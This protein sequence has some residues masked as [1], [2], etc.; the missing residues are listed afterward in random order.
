M[1][2]T[3]FV[4]GATGC[5]GINLIEQ[6]LEQGWEVTAMHRRDSDI[7]LISHL[8]LKRVVGDVTDAQSLKNLIRPGVGCV[9]HVAGNTSLWA[10]SHAEQTKVNIKGTRNMVR[11]AL[12]AG[13]R[14][15]V[16][17][18][19]IVAYGLH[20]GTISEDTPTR[21]NA[22]KINYV[23]SKALAER[24]VRRGLTRGLPAVILNPSNIIGAYD[25]GNWS[26]MFRLVQAGRLPAVPPGGGSFC[27]AREVARMHIVA[28]ER[29]RV[30]ANYLLGGPGASYLGLVREIGNLL[31]LK[32]RVAVLPPQVLS[33]Y[34]R[35]EEWL[36]PL[37]GRTPDITRDAVELLSQN[38][39]C[40]SRRAITELGYQPQSLQTML[41]DCRDW[42]LS[43]KIIKP[44]KA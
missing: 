35:V 26:R 31:G 22:E 41:Q 39:Y 11:A 18:S 25:T 9:F 6:L 38:I 32:R 2:R 23:R 12:D 29:G 28:A 17:T 16:H 34:A 36:A 20:G 10:K 4:T 40:D 24:E 44:P 13:A 1:A 3:A 43:Q 33:V 5:V 21:G 8:R 15:F 14:R 19:S 7:R 30:G 37:F 27:H 42:L